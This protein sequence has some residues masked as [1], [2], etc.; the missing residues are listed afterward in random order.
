M[1]KP[2]QASCARAARRVSLL[3]ALA[4]LW[5]A[6]SARADAV[7]GNGQAATES[8]AIGAFDAIGLSGSIGL[9]L[10]QGSPTALVV[11]ADANLLPMLE[12]VVEGDQLKVRWKHGTSLRTNSRTWVEVTAP[13]VRAIASAGSGDVTIDAMKVPRLALSLQGSGD[14]RANALQSDELSLGIAGSSTV[15]LAGRAAR[16]SIN[17]SG[18]GGIE[19][20]ELRADDV[21]V[22][23]AGSGDASVHAERALSVSIAGSGN[24]TYSGDATVQ[25]AIAGSGTVRKR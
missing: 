24:V 2:D 12:T 15:T 17:V 21:R 3:A 13:Q 1:T 9:Q 20:A 23:I 7:I 16:V 6:P 25:R 11:H 18:S 10:R 8:R 4:L 22:N 5:I 19:A 14:V